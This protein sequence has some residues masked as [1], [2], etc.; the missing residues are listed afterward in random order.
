MLHPPI[1]TTVSGGWQPVTD[2]DEPFGRGHVAT[3]RQQLLEEAKKSY[4]LAINR[5]WAGNAAGLFAALGA[6]IG[7]K[8]QTLHVLDA[9]FSFALGIVF[10]AVG[11]VWSLIAQTRILRHYENAQGLLDLPVGISRRPSL[12][13]RDFQTF[14]VF[15]SFMC[16][17]T[18]GYFGLRASGEAYAVASEI[19]AR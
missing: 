8:A 14:M 2:D 19:H 3:S 5:L 7:G 11:A 6:F 12:Y 1:Q 4:E 18:G 10:M 17:F 13:W 16:F 15:V 9:L